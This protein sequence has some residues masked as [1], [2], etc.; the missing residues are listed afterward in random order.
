MESKINMDYCEH[1]WNP[2]F[3][4]SYV[5]WNHLE[6][7][8]FELLPAFETTHASCTCKAFSQKSQ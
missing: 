8:N 1:A 3:G 4:R 6:P 2:H 7:S 5:T